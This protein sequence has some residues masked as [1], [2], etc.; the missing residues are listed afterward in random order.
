MLVSMALA[1]LWSIYGV[2]ITTDLQQFIACFSQ[3]LQNTDL[4]KRVAAHML[5]HRGVE[6]R[7]MITGSSVH[8][9]R[10]EA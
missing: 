8:N 5:Q 2:A 7:S 1:A 6:R 9:Q 4:T 3:L 10:I